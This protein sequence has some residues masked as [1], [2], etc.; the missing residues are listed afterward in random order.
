MC[1]TGSAGRGGRRGGQLGQAAGCEQLGVGSW[2][3]AGGVGGWGGQDFL[4]GAWRLSPV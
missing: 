2:A 4:V 3:W 1:T